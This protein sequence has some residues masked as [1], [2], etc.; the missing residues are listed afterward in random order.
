M[1]RLRYQ[2]PN[3]M[4]SLIDNVVI[5]QGDNGTH[6][7][8]VLKTEAER[9]LIYRTKFGIPLHPQDIEHLP[10]HIAKGFTDIPQFLRPHF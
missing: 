8:I 4:L 9:R 3:G 10:A 7:S 6:S 1:L 5:F 2:R